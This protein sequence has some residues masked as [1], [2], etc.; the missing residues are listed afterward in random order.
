MVKYLKE[1]VIKMEYAEAKNFKHLINKRAKIKQD[2]P[3]YCTFL[4]GQKGTIKEVYGNLFLEFDKPAKRSK[5]DNMPMSG[6]YLTPVSFEV[7]K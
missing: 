4:Y 5:D 3:D 7:L 1:G 6:V 2:L